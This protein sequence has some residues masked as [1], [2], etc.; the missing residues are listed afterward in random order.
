MEVWNGTP[1]D[2]AEVEAARWRCFVAERRFNEAAT[3]EEID[4]AIRELTD[5]E[6]SFNE[7]LRAVRQR[8]AAYGV[9]EWRRRR[10]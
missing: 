4:A 2:N 3:R 7:V 5:A 10:R 9:T 8:F 1:L 6:R